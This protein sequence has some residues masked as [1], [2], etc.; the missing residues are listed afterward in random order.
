MNNV[1]K[2]NLHKPKQSDIKPIE[3]LVDST[4]KNNIEP[5]TAILS[6]LKEDEKIY[7]V[8]SFVYRILTAMMNEKDK[9]SIGEWISSGTIF[10]LQAKLEEGFK[11]SLNI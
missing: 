9:D 10:L 2:F 4:I 6:V 8:Q 11:K 7:A 1:L 3:G 5:L